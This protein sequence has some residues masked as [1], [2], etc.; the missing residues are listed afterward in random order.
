MI[1]SGYLWPCGVKKKWN[2]IQVTQPHQSFHCDANCNHNAVDFDFFFSEG[3]KNIPGKAVLVP[4]VVDER[5]KKIPD[6]ILCAASPQKQA[7]QM[8]E[9]MT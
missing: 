9:G 6:Q 4:L 7:N 2:W 5:T 3:W 8:A 1:I